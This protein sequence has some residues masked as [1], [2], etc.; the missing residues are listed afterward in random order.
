MRGIY[1]MKQHGLKDLE[2]QHLEPVFE[3]ERGSIYDLLD[4]DM[5]SHIGMISSKQGSVRG[6]HYHK[7]AKQ[8]TYLLEGQMELFTKDVQDDQ[9]EVQS[10]RLRKGDIISIPPY[11]IHTLKALKDSVF[12]IFTDKPRSEGGYEDDTYRVEI[13]K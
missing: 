13:A 2:V 9:A 3:D 7:T 1:R 12:L 10:V 8:I 4:H 6:N 11:T 5:I